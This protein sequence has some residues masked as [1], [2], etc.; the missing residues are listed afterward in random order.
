[1]DLTKNSQRAGNPCGT[2]AEAMILGDFSRPRMK[3]QERCLSCA[4]T[5]FVSLTDKGFH[6]ITLAFS[7]KYLP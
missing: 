7:P 6:E 5:V 3:E 2:C 4:L 1:M